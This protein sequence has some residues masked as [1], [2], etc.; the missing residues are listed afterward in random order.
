MFCLRND[1]KQVANML[2][3]GFVQDWRSCS[4]TSGQVAQKIPE[5]IA[6]RRGHAKS[7]IQPVE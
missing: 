6:C 5:A 1:A 3:H 4:S 2:N 7:V